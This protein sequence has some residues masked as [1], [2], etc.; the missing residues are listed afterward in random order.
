[1]DRPAFHRCHPR[2]RPLAALFALLLA[3]VAVWLSVAAPLGANPLEID[4]ITVSPSQAPADG[5]RVTVSVRLSDIGASGETLTLTASRGAFG[6]AAG[7]TRVVLHVEPGADGGAVATAVLIGD[8][9]IG[10]ATITASSL[11]ASRSV[12]VLFFG[13]PES[14]RFEE[15]PEGTLPAGVDHAVTVQAN[16]RLGGAAPEAMV[17]LRTTAGTLSAGEQSGSSVTVRTDSSGRAR[18]VLN[19]PPGEARLTA[20]SGEVSAARD[21][22]LVGAPARVQLL[23]LRSTI[24]LHDSP[25][26]APPNSLVAVVHDATGQPVPNV[27]V[28]FTVDAPGVS[29]VADAPD[30]S[31]RTGAS[32]AVRAHLSSGPESSTGPVQVTARVGD[33]ASSVQMRI[34]GPPSSL[35]VHLTELP[36]GVFQLRA[37][38]E[39]AEG[40]AVATGFEVEWEALNVAPE[41]EIIF[42]PPRSLV[43]KGLAETRVSAGETPPGAVTIRATVVGADP[44]LTVAAALPAP[45]PTMGTPLT[46]GLNAL[47]WAG[48][49][50][51]ISGVVEPIARVVIA[52]WRFDAGA[53][54]QAYFPSIGLGEDFLIARGDVL[55]LFLSL[56]VLLPEV[57]PLPG[58]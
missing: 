2:F 32:G 11:G 24:N 52:A 47:V 45:L 33:L 38:V 8:G 34:T 35:I 6:I 10:S 53:G 48:A 58:G 13:A 15:P 55:Y 3:L 44:P 43:S 49:T 39:D 30:G 9:R 50:G 26:P 36:G 1:M 4:E 31:L 12:T 17:T 37:T 54:W 25:F 51:S 7:P 21:L 14:L 19:A 18:A 23:S 56:P 29:V 20:R 41:A 5:G 42:D 57:E 46:A 40:F 28:A 22:L 16:D 27:E